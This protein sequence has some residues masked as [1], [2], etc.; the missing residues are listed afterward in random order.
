MQGMDDGP[1]TGARNLRLVPFGLGRD[2]GGDDVPVGRPDSRVVLAHDQATITAVAASLRGWLSRHVGRGGRS[3]VRDRA[4]CGLDVGRRPRVGP[5]RP[6]GSRRHARPRGRLPTHSAEGRL[7]REVPQPA[8]LPPRLLARGLVGRA[9]DG[10]QEWCLVRG[11]L[12][13]AHGRAVRVGHHEPRLDG[14]RRRTD[15]SR[16]DTAVAPRRLAMGPQRSSSASAY[17]C[18]SHPPQCRASAPP[19]RPRCTTCPR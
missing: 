19:G 9:A 7:P 6:M 14:R 13:G 3:R 18:S 5:R 2:D 15:R 10:R 1:W 8:R 17:S 12:L 16:E 4:G 11:L